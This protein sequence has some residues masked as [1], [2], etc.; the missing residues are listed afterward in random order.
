MRFGPLPLAEAEGA[1]LAHSLD[2]G[3]D[4][5]RKG[6]RLDRAALDLIRAAGRDS[7]VAARLE[8]GDLDEDAAAGRIGASLGAAG[9]RVGPA[10]TGRV[11]LHAEG[12]GVLEVDADRVAAVNGIDPMITLATLRP[13]ARVVAGAMVATVKII[14][15]GV[16]GADAERAAKAAGIHCIAVTSTLGRDLLQE[17][18]DVVDTLEDFRDL[19]Q[20][21]TGTSS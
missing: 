20:G 6:T 4:R 8:A 12:P 17:A 19:L 18:D 2:L 21:N 9:L 13:Y 10:A 15:Y 7:V 14:A 3:R 11:N 5:L 1:I 16:A